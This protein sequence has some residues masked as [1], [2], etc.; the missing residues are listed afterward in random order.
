MKSLMHLSFFIGCPLFIYGLVSY[1]NNIPTSLLIT[2]VTLL[3]ISFPAIIKDYKHNPSDD[4]HSTEDD[5]APEFKESNKT[6]FSDDI[7]EFVEGLDTESIEFTLY[8]QYRDKWMKKI[9]NIKS[10]PKE[11]AE[12]VVA[13]KEYIDNIIPDIWWMID[14]TLD[15]L[16]RLKYLPDTIIESIGK[17]YS[18]YLDDKISINCLNDT[19]ITTI[20]ARIECGIDDNEKGYK[21]LICEHDLTF[22]LLIKHN[23]EVIYQLATTDYEFDPILG[24]LYHF[25]AENPSDIAKTLSWIEPFHRIG[26]M[27]QKLE[28]KDHHQKK[29]IERAQIAKLNS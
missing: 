6:T 23:E 18:I 3:A 25:N 1:G 17:R 29:L 8:S 2:S 16:E 27:I 28:S 5:N 7:S 24:V 11:T 21:F 10:M 9:S 4:N 22:Y 26:C 13:R 12:E 19:K 15:I 14:N 20:N